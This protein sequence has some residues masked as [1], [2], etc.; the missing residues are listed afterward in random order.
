MPHD[1]EP[2][3][4]GGYPDIRTTKQVLLGAAIVLLI[5]A[6]IILYMMFG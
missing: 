3:E 2:T 4:G 6:A 5:A 1:P